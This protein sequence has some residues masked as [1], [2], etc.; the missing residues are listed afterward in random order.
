M[1]PCPHILKA[2][3]FVMVAGQTHA[4]V[5]SLTRCEIRNLILKL[6]YKSDILY[7]AELLITLLNRIQKWTVLISNLLCYYRYCGRG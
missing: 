6:W 7:I 4:D 1:F 2:R 3:R 5:M